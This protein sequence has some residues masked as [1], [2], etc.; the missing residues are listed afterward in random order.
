MPN[1]VATRWRAHVEQLARDAGRVSCTDR[2]CFRLADVASPEF[3]RRKGVRPGA[4]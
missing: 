1:K 3:V 4:N 2:L